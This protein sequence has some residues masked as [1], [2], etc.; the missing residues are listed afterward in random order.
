MGDKVDAIASGIAVPD[1]TTFNDALSILQKYAIEEKLPRTVR[2]HLRL[3]ARGGIPETPKTGHP[4]FDNTVNI[5]LGNNALACDAAC[6]SAQRLGY[7]TRII[8]TNLSGEA[9]QAGADFA[10]MVKEI[11]AGRSGSVKPTA[12]IAGGETTVTI[13]GK[14]KGGRCQEMALAFAI[15]L[16]RIYPGARNIF[17]L[18]AGTDGNDGPTDAAGAIVTPEFMEKMNQTSV[19][20]AACLADNDAY[21]F[22]RDT[23]R[24]FMTGPTYTNVC[25]IQILIVV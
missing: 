4:A 13:R 12:I 17:F 15:D 22:F 9:S 3:G 7:D 1:P 19:Q 10:R 18:S 16:H 6:W 14:G 20:A 11:D 23:G 21:H 25:D 2:E 8:S 5:I 24:L